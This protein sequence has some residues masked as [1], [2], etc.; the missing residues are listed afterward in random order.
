MTNEIEKK[1]ET[2]VSTVV[3]VNEFISAERPEGKDEGTLGNEH[4]GR[5]DILMPYL[6]LAQKTSP[7]LDPTSPRYIPGLQFTNLFNSLTR[8]TFN[9]GPLHFVILRADPPRWV[10]FRPLTEGGGIIDPNVPADDPRTQFGDIDP[11]TGRSAKPIATK[12]YDFIVLLLN[13]LDMSD[14]LQNIVALSFKSTGIRVAKRLNM[15]IQQ[16][17][18]KKLYKGVYELTSGSD[19]SNTN[20]FAIYKVKNAGWLKPDS[21]IEQ[22]VG[23]LFEVWKD[24][25]VAVHRK[26]DDD[27]DADGDAREPAQRVT[28]DKIPF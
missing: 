14:P 20:V 22:A 18:P 3:D 11:A 5:E 12:F 2:G 17:G 19:V 6:A 21:P 1:Q 23:E 25:E 8:K 28:E 27:P 26:I 24:R 10:E 13:S 9:N 15:L 4:I 16:R 7:E